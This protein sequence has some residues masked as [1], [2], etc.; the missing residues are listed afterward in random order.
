[1]TTDKRWK[2]DRSSAGACIGLID[3]GRAS[4]RT[5]G[6]FLAFFSELGPAPYFYAYSA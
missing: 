5:R 4:K 1:V 2:P 6:V 3:C